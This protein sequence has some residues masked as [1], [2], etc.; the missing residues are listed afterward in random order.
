MEEADLYF[1]EA[2]RGDAN[3]VVVVKPISQSFN[4]VKSTSDPLNSRSGHL[5]EG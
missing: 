2:L 1:E 3:V 5:S 4:A